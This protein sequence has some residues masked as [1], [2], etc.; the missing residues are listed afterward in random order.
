MI[1]SRQLGIPRDSR[2]KI[3]E[4]EKERERERDRDRG[5]E[6]WRERERERARERERERESERERERLIQN[7]RGKV[8]A[9]PATNFGLLLSTP[10]SSSYTSS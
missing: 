5:R 4:R 10:I 8:D 6:G 2:R 7:P 3:K 1:Q 9:L